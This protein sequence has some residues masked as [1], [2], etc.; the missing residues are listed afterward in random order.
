MPPTPAPPKVLRAVESVPRHSKD[1]HAFC[2]ACACSLFL[3]RARGRIQGVSFLFSCWLPVAGNNH[4]EI[5]TVSQSFCLLDGLT[6]RHIFPGPPISG[7]AP[8]VND[9]HLTP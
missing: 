2:V 8:T 5:M 9:I 7:Y 4:R 6:Q 1:G 3:L